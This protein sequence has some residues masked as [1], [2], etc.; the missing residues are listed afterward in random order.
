MSF[1]ADIFNTIRRKS[2]LCDN[3]KGIGDFS[4]DVLVVRVASHAE[5]HGNV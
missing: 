1:K 3:A 2:A 4:D 5:A